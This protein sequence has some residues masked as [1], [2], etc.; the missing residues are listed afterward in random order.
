MIAISVM[1]MVRDLFTL[2]PASAVLRRGLTVSLFVLTLAPA[3]AAATSVISVAYPASQPLAAGTLV[4][5]NKETNGVEPATTKNADNLLGAV[6][7][8]GNSLL[9]FEG[10]GSSVQVT[11]SGVTQ[12]EVSDI[13]GAINPGDSITASPIAGVGMKATTNVKIIGVAQASLA[14]S[15]GAQKQTVTDQTGKKQQVLIGTVPVDINVAYFFK[16]PDKSIIPQ[17]IQNLANTVAGREVAPL[18]ILLSAA[19]IIVSIIAISS[20]ISSAVRSSIISVG[21]NPLSQAAVYRNLLQV[22]GLILGILAAAVAAVFMILT[23]L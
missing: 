22:S 7:L 9:S 2:K 19:I 4:S 21:R 23:K 1:Q 6:V 14:S 8:D 13:N 10:S 11:T 3:L 12:V 17:T 15:S 16:T 20:L 5:L 18:P